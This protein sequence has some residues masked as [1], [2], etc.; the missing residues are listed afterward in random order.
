M[1]IQKL[2]TWFTLAANFGVVL[3]IALLAIEIRQN[4]ALLM[5]QARAF[6]EENRM[7]D[8]ILILENPELRAVITKKNQ[9]VETTPE[10]NLLFRVFQSTVINGWQATWLEHQA[11]LIEIEGYVGRWRDLFWYQEYSDRWNDTKHRYRPEFVEWMDEH[12]LSD[13]PADL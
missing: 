13:P 1:N 11:G 4:N 8:E 12:V 3:G 2:N 7:R 6:G 10:E 9:Q 5:A